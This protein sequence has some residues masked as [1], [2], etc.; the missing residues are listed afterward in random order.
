MMRKVALVVSVKQPILFA[1][2]LVCCCA[3]TGVIVDALHPALAQTR[4]YPWCQGYSFLRKCSFESWE[5]CVATTFAE[6]GR[7]FE[8]PAY[9]APSIERRRERKKRRPTT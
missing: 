4:S 6:G 2:L 9:V 1:G 5:Q 8:N 3:A 7:C